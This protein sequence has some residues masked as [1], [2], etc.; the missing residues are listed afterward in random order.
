MPTLLTPSDI[1][2][3]GYLRKVL[4]TGPLVFLGNDATYERVF[5]EWEAPDGSI[6]R[7]PDDLPLYR[8][9]SDANI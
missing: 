9:K 6:Q 4:E 5:L 7:W 1:A 3:D 8:R 2:P